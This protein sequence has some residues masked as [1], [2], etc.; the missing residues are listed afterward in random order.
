MSKLI[1]NEFGNQCWCNEKGQCHRTNGPAIVWPS[2][3]EAWYKDGKHHREDGPAY[4]S[5][6]G[7]LGW[8]I[9]GIKY[10]NNMSFQKAAKLSDEDMTA[11]VLKYGN[12]K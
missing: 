10:F 11:I 12:V 5:A 2:G 7:T 9:S 4:I 8:W 6:N 3:G 1:I